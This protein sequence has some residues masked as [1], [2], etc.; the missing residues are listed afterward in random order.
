MRQFENLWKSEQKLPNLSAKLTC[1]CVSLYCTD[2]TTN[3][4]CTFLVTLPYIMCLS[5][6]MVLH[7]TRHTVNHWTKNNSTTGNEWASEKETQPIG[8]T[9]SEWEQSEL[10][11]P[12]TLSFT[13][14]HC[15]T[16]YLLVALFTWSVSCSCN[17][18]H[19]LM[20]VVL[21]H[22]Q[23]YWLLNHT[24]L[25]SH[26]VINWM[27]HQILAQHVTKVVR[28]ERNE[29]IMVNDSNLGRTVQLRTPM[30]R[31]VYQLHHIPDVLHMVNQVKW[32]YHYT[33]LYQ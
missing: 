16:L 23:C 28:Y 22:V 9:A 24:V 1:T 18:L 19:W 32:L 29:S 10:P 12:S 30:I 5:I 14:L 4:S 15:T 31:L 8:D 17:C 21:D 7:T 13:P 6:W 2:F 11:H 25:L 26:D 27:V 20:V 3:R 33:R